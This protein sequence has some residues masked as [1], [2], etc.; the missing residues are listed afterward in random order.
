MPK[1]RWSCEIVNGE[2]RLTESFQAE[3]GE[4][5]LELKPT[6]VRSAQ[7][8]NYYWFIIG[9]LSE[10][11]GYTEPE[12][13]EVLKKHFQIE[14]TKTLSREEFGEFIEQIIRWASIDFGI[15]IPDP[16]RAV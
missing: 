13:H 15:A 14:S 11:L 4:Y 1:M 9:I 2:L 6:G 10:D 12:M 5:Y 7:Q 3:D 16:H 8:N